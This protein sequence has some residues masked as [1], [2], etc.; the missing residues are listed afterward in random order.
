MPEKRSTVQR[1][2]GTRVQRRHLLWRREC[3]PEGPVR[4]ELIQDGQTKDAG[5]V[6]RCVYVS[7]QRLL[8]TVQKG[9]GV[10]SAGDCRP[11][12]TRPTAVNSR[13]R[14]SAVNL[15]LERRRWRHGGERRNQWRDLPDVGVTPEI[16]MTAPRQQVQPR[17]MMRRASRGLSLHSGNVNDISPK[18]FA[19]LLFFFP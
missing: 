1:R 17:M 2:W 12:R 3:G 8:Q 5:V 18:A 10:E 14:F 13:Q 15:C 4:A 6:C 9:D 16:W 11:I 19:T 7:T